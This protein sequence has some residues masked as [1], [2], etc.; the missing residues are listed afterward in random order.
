MDSDRFDAISRTLGKPESRRGALVAI[1]ALAGLGALAP[2]ELDAK[3]KKKKKKKKKQS[4]TTCT[5]LGDFCGSE[6]FCKCC[7]DLTCVD[8]VC[9]L[10]QGSDCGFG[11][12]GGPCCGTLVCQPFADGTCQPCRTAGQSCNG[13]EEC[14][15]VAGKSVTC[16]AGECVVS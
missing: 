16:P 9:C 7:N 6:S 8:D 3:K 14:C 15:A 13:I 5:A 11:V 4:C 2:L 12:S 10:P 1:A